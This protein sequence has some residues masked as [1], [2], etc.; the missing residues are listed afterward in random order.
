M[1]GSLAAFLLVA[2]SATDR[3]MRSMFDDTFSGIHQMAWFDWAMLIPYFAVLIILS[4]YGLHRYDIIRTYFKHR[5][6]ATGDPLKHFE[7]LPPVTIQLPLYNERYVVERLIDEVTKVEYPKEL[8]QIQVLDDSTDDTAP[9][10]EALVE[11]YRALGYPIEYHHRTNRHGFKAGALQAGLETATG[12]F[13]AVFDADFCPPADFLMRTVH[14]FADP[15]VGVVQ[16]RWSY[17]N[18][19]YNFLTEVE[20]MLLDGHFILEHGARSRAGYFFNFNGTAGILR[21]NMIADAGGWQHD[22]LTEDSDLSYRAQLKGWRFVYLPGLDCPSELPVEMH[23]FQVQQS[24]W[25]KGL[26]QTALKLLPSILKAKLPFRVK[27]EAFMHLTPN[28]SYPLM[29]VVS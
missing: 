20:S 21:K 26:T 18:R 3:L 13:V 17:L 1:F 7:T 19:D 9:F 16:T 29:I 6:K 5:K 4:V 15:A 10:A 24:R 28:I 11:R 22:T 8:L 12:E 25:A 23:G 2:P 27:A 14:Y